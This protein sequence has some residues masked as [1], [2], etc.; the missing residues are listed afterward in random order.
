MQ[1]HFFGGTCTG[2]G[3]GRQGKEGARCALAGSGSRTIR[4]N[5]FRPP[6]S[7]ED[8]P[9]S[10]TDTGLAA[11]TIYFYRLRSSNSVGDSDDTGAISRRTFSLFEQW[12][13]NAGFSVT[14]QSDRTRT[15]DVPALARIAVVGLRQCGAIAHGQARE[16]LIAW[17]CVLGGTTLARRCHTAHSPHYDAENRPPFHHAC[18]RAALWLR[19]HQSNKPPRQSIRA[20]ES[21]GFERRGEVGKG[22]RGRG[23]DG[24]R[25]AS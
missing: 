19:R 18:R 22:T 6:K 17:R 21:A 1:R 10:F 25:D 24:N 20:G 5:Q 4:R 2:R 16:S 9:T 8:V 12:K 13:V 23:R 3:G 7:N 11:N 15:A 14:A